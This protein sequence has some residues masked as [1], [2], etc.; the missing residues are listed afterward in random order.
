MLKLSFGEGIISFLLLMSGFFDLILGSLLC[1]LVLL[2]RS[3]DFLG[4]LCLST[5]EC[6]VFHEWSRN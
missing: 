6:F 5:E 4:L 1:S 3:D 2:S